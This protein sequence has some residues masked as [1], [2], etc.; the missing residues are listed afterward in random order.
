MTVTPP[1]LTVPPVLPGS[2][3][4]GNSLAF[5]RDPVAVIRQ[6]Q[7]QEGPVFALRLG[8]KRAAVVVGPQQSRETIA[9]PETTLAVQPVYQWVKPMFGDVMQAADHSRYLQQRAALLPA[10]QGRRHEEYLTGMLAEIRPWIDE[11]GESGGFDAA[12]DLERLS[13]AIAVRLFL[14]EQFRT[15][16]ADRFTALFL[17]IAAGMEFF[18][19]ANLPIPR[20]LRRNRARR[21]MFALM[22]PHLQQVRADPDPDRYGFLAQLVAGSAEPGATT[23]D[24]ETLIGM[25]LILTY[26]AYETT[27]AQL[28]WALVEL[29]RNPQ[30]A[31]AVVT[32]VRDVLPLDA[33]E[34]GVKDLHRLAHLSRCLLETQRLRPVTTMLTRQT[35]A[36]YQ[37][38]GFTVPAGWQTLFCPPVTHRDP[39]V[40]P[41]PDRFDPDRFAPER[42]PKG[43]AFTSLLNLGGGLHACLG[44]RFAD[45]EMKAVIGLLLQ[46]YQ[47]D[48]EHPDPPVAPGLGLMRPARPCVIRYRARS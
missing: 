20:L 18:L 38:G 47:L 30:P 48:L 16:R 39:Q 6:G 36:D 1:V 13:M 37:V 44:A 46:R 19:P 32:E 3:V 23:F 2:R 24:D 26:A 14:G 43:Q 15:E 7:A 11:L 10:L 8:P 31:Q 22:G 45:L 27:A 41:D 34:I 25:I 12:A 42:D 17:D 28:A 21:Q 9:L 29:A 40:F 4:L 35:A 33:A 5:M